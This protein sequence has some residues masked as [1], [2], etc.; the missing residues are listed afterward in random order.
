MTNIV[1]KRSFFLQ[2]LHNV[3]SN[4]A[5]FTG[6]ATRGDFWFLCLFTFLLK[7][8][9]ASIMIIIA[10]HFYGISKILS[11]TQSIDARLGADFIITL[12]LYAYFVFLFYILL[13]S[14]T[15]PIVTTSVRRLHDVGRS[16]W[17]LLLTL[18]V[19]GAIPLFI[20]FCLK[21][22]PHDN[23]YGPAPLA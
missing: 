1:K 17:W 12:S 10:L 2:S 7:L 15:L 9:C 8:F 5:K 13:F 19:V 4:Y 21:S 18:T 20:F 23:D 22:Q 14:L 16:G 3:F 6:R 11:I